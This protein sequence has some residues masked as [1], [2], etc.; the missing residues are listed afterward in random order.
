MK[1]G[2]FCGFLAYEIDLQHSEFILATEL[3]F[4]LNDT[5]GELEVSLPARDV[6]A[7]DAAMLV[8]LV[9]AMDASAGD[10]AEAAEVA[11]QIAQTSQNLTKLLTAIDEGADAV[12][13]LDSRFPTAVT[14][15]GDL[16]RKIRP[17]TKGA[18][19]VHLRS[20]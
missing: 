15:P 14:V 17:L 12:L 11:R 1:F 18:A 4:S 10:P 9:V 5:D 7:S 6:S 2:Q 20:I 3:L 13:N 8:L 16:L 19:V